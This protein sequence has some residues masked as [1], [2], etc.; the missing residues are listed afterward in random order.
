MI[1]ISKVYE[2]NIE[3][4]RIT[5]QKIDPNHKCMPMVHVKIASEKAINTQ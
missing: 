5:Q 4:V 3:I 1:L 2:T